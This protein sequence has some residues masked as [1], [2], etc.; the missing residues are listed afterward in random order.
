MA[1]MKV[2]NHDKVEITSWGFHLTSACWEFY[3]MCTGLG[4][5]TE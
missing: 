2:I 5:D 1:L 4:Y 3:D